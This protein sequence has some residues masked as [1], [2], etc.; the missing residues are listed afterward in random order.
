[1]ARYGRG[2]PHAG[3]SKDL[4][5]CPA[6]RNSSSALT[7]HSLNFNPNLVDR[8]G[9]ERPYTIRLADNAI[10]KVTCRCVSIYSWNLIT[11]KVDLPV[12]LER[13]IFELAASADVA[14]ALRLAVVARRLLNSHAG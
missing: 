11:H 6:N 4:Q 8:C 9:H 12:E 3:S 7:M 13:E 1:M 14:T 10:R 5:E 2:F